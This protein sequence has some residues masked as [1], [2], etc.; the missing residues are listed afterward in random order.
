[1]TQ[2]GENQT[3]L[4]A[5]R[6]RIAAAAVLAL[7]LAAGCQSWLAQRFAIPSAQKNEPE[8]KSE[9]PPQAT[10]GELAAILA[11]GNAWSESIAGPE[12]REGVAGNESRPR[13]C[14]RALEDYLS[15]P[16]A[17]RE[18][19]RLALAGGDET[20]AANAAV[21]LARLGDAGGEKRL[22]AAVSSRK[23]KL[24]Q[25]LAAAEALGLLSSTT[26]A[27]S[28]DELIGQY[29][30]FRL[31]R[32]SQ[33]IPPLHA[34]LLISLSKRTASENEPRFLEALDSPDAGVRLSAVRFWTGKQTGK[35]ASLPDAVADLTTDVNPRVRGEALMAVSLYRHLQAKDRL[36][37]GL[38]DGDIQVRTATIAAIGRWADPSARQMLQPLLQDRSS[39]IRAAAVAALGEQGAESDV[40]AAAGDESWR[41]RAAVARTLA[42]HPGGRAEGLARRLLDDPSLEVQE[43]LLIAVAV[44]PPQ[45]CGPILL[46][47]IKGGGPRIRK[48]AAELLAERWPPAAHF[49][50]TATQERRDELFERLKTEFDR[51]YRASGDSVADRTPPE[52]SGD[53]DSPS[54]ATALELVVKLQSSDVSQRR[55]A[56][57]KL[58]IA[59][60]QQPLEA[61]A[62]ERLAAAVARENDQLVWQY[63]LAAVARDDSRSA[64]ELA[65]AAVGHASS[66]VRRLGCEHLGAHPQP[67][68]AAV[69]LP[70][71]DD[72]NVSV[73]KAAVAALGRIG[74]KSD[75]ASI[76]K[77]LMS[78]N[79]SLQLETAV[80][81]A[82]MGDRDGDAALRRLT[83]DDDPQ[84]RLEVARAMGRSG[85]PLFVAD[86]VRLLDDRA[87]VRREALAALE[88]LA[89]ENSPRQSRQGNETTA[90]RVALWKQWYAEQLR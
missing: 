47:A 39:T 46:A 49:P 62:V 18:A 19:L 76:K 28:L 83:F 71:V 23:L 85:N 6:R 70:A 35:N 50:Y 73:A 48:L 79:S 61:A 74:R 32:K 30:D 86:L 60:A 63:A 52:E 42:K 78:Q 59:A 26:V 10:G 58:A 56:A 22:V 7:A 64:A 51:Q 13:W 36:Q 11:D 69:L 24:P 75:T 72:E 89:P 8:A 34:E 21:A 45:S 3:S 16:Q 38:H 33:Y 88:T 84:I 68:R 2:S 4:S 25:R 87:G 67:D 55:R 90:Q 57:E 5:A 37:G 31:G 40:S 66:E 41:V 65:C 54:D 43:Q 80:A 15:R 20:A 29:G 27:A 44:W 77:L 14:N 81:L 17:D 53:G 12:G 82:R 1:M 9:T